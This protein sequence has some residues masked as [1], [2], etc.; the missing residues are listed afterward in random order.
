MR[1]LAKG[2]E[3]EFSLHRTLQTKRGMVKAAF[4]KTIIFR[5]FGY[6]PHSEAGIW[7]DKYP[8]TGQKRRLL[9]AKLAKWPSMKL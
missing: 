1:R 8:T 6:E 2:T 9:A 3:G 5:S 7:D 4:L